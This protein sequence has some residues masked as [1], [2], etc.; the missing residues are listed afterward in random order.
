MVA[1]PTGTVTFLFADIER[2]TSLLESLCDRYAEVLKEYQRLLRTATGA[3]GGQEVDTQG[4]ACFIAFSR[5]SDA[6]LAAVESQRAILVH[7][8]PEGVSVRVRMGLHTG[9]PHSSETG[10]VGIDVHLDPASSS[11]GP[12]H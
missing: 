9:E 11:S 4:D 12:K 6:L 7:S 10:Y 5:A 3:R 1:L 2:S 8:W